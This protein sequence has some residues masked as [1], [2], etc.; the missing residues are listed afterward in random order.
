MNHITP[1][2]HKEYTE[3][4]KTISAYL[5]RLDDMQ[6]LIFDNSKS[7]SAKD[8]I[9]ELSKS[10]NQLEECKNVI[11]SHLQSVPGIMKHCERIASLHLTEDQLESAGK[12][13]N[14]D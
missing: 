7:D 9:Q 1:E 5:T 11:M 4:F 12:P 8:A 2:M 10:F 6:Q 14:E 13:I 3:W